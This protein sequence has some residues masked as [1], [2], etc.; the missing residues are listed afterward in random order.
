MLDQFLWRHSSRVCDISCFFFKGQQKHRSFSWPYVET[1]SKSATASNDLSSDYDAIE[2]ET[3][4]IVQKKKLA[5]GHLILQ[6][7]QK[8]NSW[9]Q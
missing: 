7:Y 2:I 3:S 1:P 8:Q 5:T 6:K 9:P 4:E